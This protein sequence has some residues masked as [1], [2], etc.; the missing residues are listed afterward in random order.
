MH[1][2]TQGVRSERI[3]MYRVSERE[4]LQI[5]FLLFGENEGGRLPAI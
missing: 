2:A 3:I 1:N 5:V 4:L